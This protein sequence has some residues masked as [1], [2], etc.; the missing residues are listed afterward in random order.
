[1]HYLAL[2]MN[3][4]AITRYAGYTSWN[5]GINTQSEQQSQQ[6]NLIQN[7][8]SKASFA[9][10]LSGKFDIVSQRV[11][12][13]TKNLKLISGYFKN[14]CKEFEK[15]GKGLGKTLTPIKQQVLLQ[16]KGPLDSW[17]Y[18]LKSI[19]GSNEDYCKLIAKICSRYNSEIIE[20]FELFIGHYE[21]SNKVFL[22][23]CTKVLETLGQ[24][25]TKV[26][27]AKDKYIKSHQ[28][29]TTEVDEDIIKQR[30]RA[31]SEARDEYSQQVA[32][33]NAY[34][35]EKEPYYKK[36][37]ESIQQNEENRIEFMRKHFADFYNVSQILVQEFTHMHAGLKKVLEI[38][39]P[40][41]DLQ[42]FVTS[43]TKTPKVNVFEKANFDILE[44]TSTNSAEGTNSRST[45]LRKDDSGS[46]NEA[47]DLA[48]E[49]ETFMK[50]VWTKLLASKDVDAG[51][52]TRL[53]E[54]LKMEKCRENFLQN[55]AKQMRK[56]QV[57]N[58]ECFAQA[59][60]ILNL[61]LSHASQQGKETLGS[62][63]SV[64]VTMGGLLYCTSP[65]EKFMKSTV[66]LRDLLSTHSVWKSKETWQAVIQYRLSRSMSQVKTSIHER[67]EEKSAG[68]VK[69]VLDVSAKLFKNKDKELEE[70]EVKEAR[71]EAGKRAVIYSDL[72]IIAMELALMDVNPDVAREVLTQ[73]SL[74]YK[75]DHEKVYQML[76][77]Y[78]SARSLKRIQDPPIEGQQKA[79]KGKTERTMAKYSFHKYGIILKHSVN[80]LSDPQTLCNLLKSSKLFNSK[81]KHLVYKKIVPMSSIMNKHRPQIWAGLLSNASLISLQREYDKL[82]EGKLKMFQ[83]TNKSIEEVIR[84]DVSRSF[85]I[86][87]ESTQTSI[88]NILRCYAMHNPELEYCQGMNFLAGIVFLIYQNESLAFSIFAEL[89]KSHGLSNIYKQDVPLLRMYL[90]QM[91]RIIAIFLP[92]LH[93]H[94]LE[95]GIGANHFCA[96]W[97]LTAFTFI[98]QHTKAPVI[99][100]LLLDIFDTFLLVY[101]I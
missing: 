25:R 86:H 13:E 46:D 84:L 79:Q 27:K 33:L 65:P 10:N 6:Y 101:F 100:P 18:A 80:Y 21:Q 94:L 15:L 8:E 88:M 59:G 34:I 49:V 7:M 12:Q 11:L 26:R 89:V 55:F 78:E 72:I 96:P 3:A 35:S 57:T 67:R 42:L 31:M 44:G 54:L 47:G 73:F 19:I 60:D 39:N 53:A 82:K 41:G 97:F 64:V 70:F 30:K 81:L 93:R 77:D 62:E 23:E 85:H 16:N 24:Q 98:L 48:E 90:H 32:L 83:A 92:N 61:M 58:Y 14:I 17:G 43:V 36:R 37:L 87:A 68:L 22:K 28:K 52:R 2:I 74:N 66:F 38:V 50:S 4:T 75:L 1:M 45:S 76:C 95:E 20:P 56:Q 9:E 91:T 40:M 51:E 99:P 5:N 69:R 63:L 29:P 71:E